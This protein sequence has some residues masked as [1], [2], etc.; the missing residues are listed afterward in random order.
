MLIEIGQILGSFQ[1]KF[2]VVGGAVPWLLLSEADMPH[3]GTMDVDL[4]LNPS[5]LGDGQYVRL[6]E[7]LQTHGY[8]QET[9][10]GASNSSARSPLKGRRTGH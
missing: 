1:G 6:V 7:A 3:S 8:H 10:C 9:I 4:G 5:A 2:A